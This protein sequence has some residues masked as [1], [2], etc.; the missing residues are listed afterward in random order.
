MSLTFDCTIEALDP[1]F[2]DQ[3]AAHDTLN[4]LGLSDATFD[5]AVANAL[6]D[7]VVTRRLSKVTLSNCSLP[8]E[9]LPAIT[10]LLSTGSLEELCLCSTELGFLENQT[11]LP[12]FCESLRAVSLSKLTLCDCSLFISPLSSLSILASFTALSLLTE[13][14]L[15]CN[16]LESDEARTA[17]GIHLAQI[18][19]VTPALQTL[20]VNY[21]LL[22]D[23]GVRPLF[24]AV[25][26]STTLRS[27]DCSE[28]EVSAECARDCI[29]PAVQVNTSLR[30]LVLDDRIPELRQAMEL[31]K[32]RAGVA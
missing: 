16:E 6:A 2:V 31:V 11:A 28:N 14:N 1:P 4:S 29:L 23:A 15:S 13:L 5:A 21:C 32:A 18:L 20:N 7:A 30:S 27:L 9:V 10:R 26:R 25:A 8:A 12:I 19:A 24:A 22:H 17:A 3:I